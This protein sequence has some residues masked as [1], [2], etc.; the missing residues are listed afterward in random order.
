MVDTRVRLG[1]SLAPA[2][3]IGLGIYFLGRGSADPP[4]RKPQTVVASPVEGPPARF[5]VPPPREV[6]RRIETDL[7][8]ETMGEIRA[9]PPVADDPEVVNAFLRTARGPGSEERRRVAIAFLGGAWDQTGEVRRVLLD[10]ARSDPSER[11]RLSAVVA[12]QEYTIRNFGV[13]EEVNRELLALAAAS[14]VKLRA[15]ALESLDMFQASE[16]T[17]SAMRAYEADP[18]PE[19]RAAVYEKLGDQ[20]ALPALEAAFAREVDEPVLRRIVIAVA[21]AA[22]LP[23]LRRMAE[24]PT[25]VRDEILTAIRGLETG[26]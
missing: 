18:S 6:V 8:D 21:R 19:V 1:I 17:V 15:A 11:V 2:I 20:R 23:V 26:E 12:F 25:A 9:N 16:A 4:V 5:D 22:A 10:L 24:R 14:G 7:D 3:A 13:A